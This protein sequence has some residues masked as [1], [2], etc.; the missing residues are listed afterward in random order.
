LNLEILKNIGNATRIMR[1]VRGPRNWNDH[2]T[3]KSGASPRSKKLPALAPIQ[4]KTNPPGIIP[5]TVVHKKFFK[6]TPARA[7]KILATK[8]GTTGINRRSKR[9]LI[10][11]TSAFQS[12]CRI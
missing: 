8:K 3:V 6:L 10:S 4:V 9:K 7:G 1:H 11:L 5:T 12:N 2:K